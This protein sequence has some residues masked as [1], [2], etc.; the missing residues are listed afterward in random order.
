MFVPLVAPEI[1][2][3]GQV[4]PVLVKLCLLGSSEDSD[5]KIIVPAAVGIESLLND[6]SQIR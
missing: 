1:L 5:I 6:T 3:R 4:G 2:S